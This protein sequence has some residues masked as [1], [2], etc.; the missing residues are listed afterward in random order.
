MNDLDDIQNER[1]VFDERLGFETVGQVAFGNLTDADNEFRPHDVQ[2]F[3]QPVSTGF[4]FWFVRCSPVSVCGGVTGND[5]G[6]DGDRRRSCINRPFERIV[7]NADFDLTKGRDDESI[8]F[9]SGRTDEWFSNQVFGFAWGFTDQTKI[10]E[11]GTPLLIDGVLMGCSRFRQFPVIGV[12]IPEEDDFGASLTEGT[13]IAIAPVG[14]MLLELQDG[15]A[16]RGE[17]LK[18]R[19]ASGKASSPGHAVTLAAERMY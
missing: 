16:E 12:E 10:A 9:I 19:L 11:R 7:C 18:H 1:K 6:Q 14:T 4:D 15:I 2:E 3:Y 13:E 17:G 5:V 8:Q